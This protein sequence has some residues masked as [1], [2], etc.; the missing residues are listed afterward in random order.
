VLTDAINITARMHPDCDLHHPGTPSAT[1]SLIRLTEDALQYLVLGDTTVIVETVDGIEVFN[2]D[3]VETTAQAERAEANRYPFGSAQKQ[4]ALL[5]M[6]HAE[7]ALR[8]QPGGFWVA[9]ADPTVVTH[10]IT[11]QFP[12]NTVRRVAVLTDGATRLV[13]MFQLLDWRGVLDVLDEQGPTELIRR[14]RAIEAADPNGTRWPRNKGSDDATV[15][16]AR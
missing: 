2:D 8:N 3:R 12:L 13:S 5:R 11:G 14:V 4:A 10:A 7:L 16:Y 15:V 6:K 9:A 1:T